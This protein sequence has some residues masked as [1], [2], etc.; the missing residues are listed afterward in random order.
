[1]DSREYSASQC[2][3]VLNKVFL[4][5]CQTL[6]CKWALGLYK[7]I[8]KIDPLYIYKLSFIQMCLR[9]Y[10]YIFTCLTPD[11]YQKSSHYFRIYENATEIGLFKV[12]FKL[13]NKRFFFKL[14]FLLKKGNFPF[15]FDYKNIM[16]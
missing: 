2:V 5:F 13:K 15:A 8:F 1:M 7:C 16:F 12:F 14:V 11:N 4:L 9:M 10:P 6:K 3:S